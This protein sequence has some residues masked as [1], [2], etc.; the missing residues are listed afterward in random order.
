MKFK[1]TLASLV[2]AGAMALGSNNAK[3]TLIP[4]E[5]SIPDSYYASGSILNPEKS[6]DG[7]FDTYAESL[8]KPSEFTLTETYNI[9][10]NTISAEWT[11]KFSLG[12][13]TIGKIDYSIDGLDWVSLYVGN[14]FDGKNI[15][16]ILNKSL[17]P[18][19]D[20]GK[21]FSE[22]D[23]L[24]FRS[25]FITPYSFSGL[26]SY[27]EGKITGMI[28]PEVATIA[29]LGLGSLCLLPKRR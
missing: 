3:A 20:F 5:Q 15:E 12:G 24:Y 6:V 7:D 23:N 16:E 1:K 17:N 18:L 29:L 11:S 4:F 27:N 19:E 25:Q 26:S 14:T 13:Y 8:G 28:L 22:I 9:P 10:E 2:M 21:Q